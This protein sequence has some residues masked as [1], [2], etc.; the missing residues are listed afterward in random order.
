MTD[1]RDIS[2]EEELLE[3]RNQ[4]K[5]SEAEYQ[6][7]LDAMRKSASDDFQP[8]AST[9]SKVPTSLKVVAVLFIIGGVLAVIEILVALTHGRININFGVLGLFIG[10]GLLRFSRGWRTCG[11]IFLWI[12]LIVIPIIFLIGLTGTFPTYFMVFGVR[13]ARIHPWWV[14][15][16]A[17]PFFLLVLWQYRVL[18]R[19]DIRRLFGLT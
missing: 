15:V 9:P 4:G 18:T 17:V 3:L 14:L 2:S 1:R 19:P 13:V 16:A 12:G 11:L 7:L 10:P 8:A 5:I 6:E